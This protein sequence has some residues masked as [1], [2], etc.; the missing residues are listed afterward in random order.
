MYANE[1]SLKTAEFSAAKKLSE[2]LLDQLRM[3]VHRLGER[4][5]NDPQA[6]ELVAESRRDRDAVEHR[7]DG[8]AGE[9]LLLVDRDAELVECGAH[10]RIDFVEAVQHLLLLRRRVVNDVLV[11]DRVVLDVLPGRLFHRE[12]EAIRLQAPLE[13]PLRLVLLLRDQPHDVFAETF[14]NRLAFDVGDEP[15]LVFAIGELFDGLG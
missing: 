3:V 14:G 15:V 12:P 5:E 10:F 13:Q 2:V 1:P 7:V 9:D 8:D 11:V 4:H 6:G